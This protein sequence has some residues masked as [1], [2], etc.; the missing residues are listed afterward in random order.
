MPNLALNNTITEHD[1]GE[2]QSL[3]ARICGRPTLERVHTAL[4]NKI[5]THPNFRAF[6]A[7]TDQTH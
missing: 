7:K 3:Y 5:F 1:F 6:F 4:Y 2:D